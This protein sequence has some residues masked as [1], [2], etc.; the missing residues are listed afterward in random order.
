GA[1]SSSR[2]CNA[3][4]DYVSETERARIRSPRWVA[5]L[6]SA[7]EEGKHMEPAAA[8]VQQPPNSKLKWIVA[9]GCCGCA[10]VAVI[11][12]ALVGGGAII[13]AASLTEPAKQDARVFLADMGKGDVDAAYAHFTR[14]LQEKLSKE[15]LTAE[16]TKHPEV[17]QLAD[18]PSY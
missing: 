16:A 9:A 17:Y 7:S 5:R 6:E 10:L 1:R 3:A 18:D 4:G 11:F 15:K 13:A 12:F 8:P 14:G 2:N